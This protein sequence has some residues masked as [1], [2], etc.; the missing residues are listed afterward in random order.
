MGVGVISQLLE[1]ITIVVVIY[2]SAPA[3]WC[4][5][6]CKTKVLIHGT[7]GAFGLTVTAWMENELIPHVVFF[8]NASH[9]KAVAAWSNHL[10]NV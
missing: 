10:Y 9:I 5:T 2:L 8:D 7:K 6:E 1:V 3:E 4:F